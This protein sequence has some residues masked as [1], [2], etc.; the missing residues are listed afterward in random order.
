MIRDYIRNSNNTLRVLKDNRVKLEKEM[1]KL[2]FGLRI[3]SAADD[4][5]GLSIS[6]K[7]RAQIRGLRQAEN[8]IQDGISLTQIADGGMKEISEIL[9]RVREL[10]VQSAN[11]TNTDSDREFI[12]AEVDEMISEIDRITDSTEFNGIK[13]LKGGGIKT[14]SYKETTVG[15]MP[16]WTKPFPDRLTQYK[17]GTYIKNDGTVIEKKY[18]IAE[19]DFSRANAGN[20]QDLVGN[21]FYSTCC[22]CTEKY[23]IKFVNGKT[24]STGSPNPIIEIDISNVQDAKTLVKEIEKQSQPYMTHFTKF[25]V[26][27]KNPDKIYIV[28]P[29]INAV[30]DI[31]KDLGIV[32]AGVV[33]TTTIN[34]TDT[35]KEIN[36]Q[37]GPNSENNLKIKL[38]DTTCDTL[39][40]IP[41]LVRTSDEARAT[42]GKIDNAIS[43]INSDRSSMGAYENRLTSSHN[44]VSNTGE[45]MQ[46]SE[47]RIRDTDMAKSMLQYSKNLILEQ[48]AQAIISQVRSS[49]IDIVKNLLMN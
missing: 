44:N 13:V 9:Q 45:N 19:I 34:G 16:Q 31:S 46:A 30:P 1:K 49:S 6:E 29:R 36:I 27:T 25:M 41:V 7:M 48:S 38:P 43:I 3:N 20:I 21:G 35:A 5:A 40:I 8:N 18:S 15:N 12:Q 37:T 33:V 28:D 24:N 26:D 22:T 47:S 2:S 4:S 10:G 39:K 32:G 23:S 42:L 14:G 11:D 17:V